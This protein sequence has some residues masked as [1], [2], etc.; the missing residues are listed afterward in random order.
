MSRNSQAIGLLVGI[1]IGTAFGWFLFNEDS[2]GYVREISELTHE[3]SRN[4]ESIQA[5]ESEL[6]ALK[7]NHQNTVRLYNDLINEQIPIKESYIDVST[8][9]IKLASEKST[10]SQSGFENADIQLLLVIKKESGYYNTLYEDIL[11]KMLYLEGFVIQVERYGSEYAPDFGHIARMIETNGDDEVTQ[12]IERYGLNHTAILF[13]GGAEIIEGF[14]DI[15][16]DDQY[17]ALRSIPWIIPD[18]ESLTQ[19]RYLYSP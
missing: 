14:P 10:N 8:L 16:S 5:I 9:C 19:F 3:I 18:R 6:S 17:S 11:M 4:E 13:L 15:M 12:A 1:I 7:V 2:S